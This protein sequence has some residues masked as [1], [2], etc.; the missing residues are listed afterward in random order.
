MLKKVTDTIQSLEWGENITLKNV[1]QFRQEMEK[2][3]HD[4]GEQTHC[5]FS[6]HQLYK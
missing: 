4:G 1:E 5:K 3:V 2:F 6:K